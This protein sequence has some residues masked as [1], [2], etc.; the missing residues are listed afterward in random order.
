[1]ALGDCNQPK[2]GLV[3][4]LE[5]IRDGFA[6]RQGKASPNSK[7]LGT[8]INFTLDGEDRELGRRQYLVPS[9]YFLDTPKMRTVACRHA[10]VPKEATLPHRWDVANISRL[11][12]APESLKFKRASH[13]RRLR[14]HDDAPQA[15]NIREAGL[16]RGRF[17]LA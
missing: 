10:P 2:S 7:C 5:A 17:R 12:R 13:E 16:S 3:D 15:H 9:T 14:I 4:F 11:L 6:C 1:M 8:T